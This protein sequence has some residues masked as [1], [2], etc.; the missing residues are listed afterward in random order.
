MTGDLWDSIESESDIV[1][2]GKVICKVICSERSEIINFTSGGSWASY[3]VFF[4][5]YLIV[6]FSLVV[7]K[8]LQGFTSNIIREK[9]D[10]DITWEQRTTVDPLLTILVQ[11]IVGSATNEIVFKSEWRIYHFPW[12]NLQS[13]V[14]LNLVQTSSPRVSI[15]YILPQNL[16][17]ETPCS[18][19]C[20]QRWY[21]SWKFAFF[22]LQQRSA[23]FYYLA[24]KY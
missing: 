13:N 14:L 20:W 21:Y 3:P 4:L 6:P 8:V 7:W 12:R 22:A 19:M 9:D 5:V 1:G 2:V 17:F 11:N 24:L 16:N 23:F 10:W 18:C 15:E